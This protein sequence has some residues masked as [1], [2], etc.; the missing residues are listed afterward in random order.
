MV[1]AIYDWPIEIQCRIC[2]LTYITTVNSDDFRD[3][4]ANGTPIQKAFDYLSND[5][6][7]LFISETCGSCF[8]KMFPPLDNDE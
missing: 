7:E 1:A 6:R 5:E 2:G 8:D 3:W 4:Y